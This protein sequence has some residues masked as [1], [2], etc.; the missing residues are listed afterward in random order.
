MMDSCKDS[1]HYCLGC[2]RQ[3][4]TVT[5]SDKVSPGGGTTAARAEWAKAVEARRVAEMQQRVMD[6]KVAAGGCGV[7]WEGAADQK[8]GC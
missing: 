5:P 3:L 7:Q 1:V 4:A 2:G 6:E 8:R